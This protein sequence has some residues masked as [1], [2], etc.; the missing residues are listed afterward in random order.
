[1]R[2]LRRRGQDGPTG[3]D[4]CGAIQLD[5]RVADTWS[6]ATA[7]SP[8]QRRILG[9][10]L[11]DLVVR[12]CGAGGGFL[13]LISGLHHPSKPHQ[14]DPAQCGAHAAHPVAQCVHSIDFAGPIGA[15]LIPTCIGMLV[16]VLIGLLVASMIRLGR[17]PQ[18]GSRSA[19]GRWMKA[20]YPGKCEHCGCSVVPGDRIRHRPGHVLCASCGER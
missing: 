3:L 15:V 9:S 12:L 13:G 18:L 8:R 1:M 11:R 6:M 2:V 4:G 7:L 14:V 5:G 20:R 17:P 19:A 10:E 16:G